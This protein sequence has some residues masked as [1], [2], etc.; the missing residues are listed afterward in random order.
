MT[1]AIAPHRTR[2]QPLRAIPDGYLTTGELAKKM[3]T[4]VRTLQFYDRIGLLIPAEETF[5]GRRLYDDANVV[6]LGQIL[7]LKQLGFSL[8]DIRDRLVNLD[9]P[10]A[11]AEALDA[12][13]DAVQAQIATLTQALTD[14]RTLRTETLRRDHVDFG[15]Y[16]EIVLALKNG[17]DRF[18][19]LDLAGDRFRARMLALD[20]ATAK[21]IWDEVIG[22]AQEA[23]ALHARGVSPRSPEGQAV[24]ERQQ[25]AVL[26]FSGGDPAVI[27]ELVAFRERS[28]EWDPEFARHYTPEA[29]EFLSQ[30]TQYAEHQPPAGP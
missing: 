13:A 3:R 5:G 29:A 9:S 16:A 12:Q 7:A 19:V 2:R 28:A 11:V 18:W 25:R 20:A 30:A 6:R 4:T 15:R 17:N 27:A 10:T 14:L 23:G 21:E 8:E 24:V 1:I 22:A 26:R